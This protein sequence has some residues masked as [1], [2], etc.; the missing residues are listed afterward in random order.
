MISIHEENNN[1]FGILTS[2]EKK[3]EVN[4]MNFLFKNNLFIL[5]L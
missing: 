5:F 3:I 1:H 2:S 4:L